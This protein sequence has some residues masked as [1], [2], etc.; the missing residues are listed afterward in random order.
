MEN[1]ANVDKGFNPLVPSPN[2]IKVETRLGEKY[3]FVVVGRDKEKWLE[4]IPKAVKECSVDSKK[5]EVM[6]NYDTVPNNAD[7]IINAQIVVYSSK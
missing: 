7:K 1:I 5:N 6:T 4:M 2:M 3:E